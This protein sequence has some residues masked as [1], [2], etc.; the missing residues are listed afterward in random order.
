MD[1]PLKYTLHRSD[2]L[3]KTSKAVLW[4]EWNEDGTF[5]EK[6][7]EPA[8]G[9]SLLMSPF[10]MAFTWQTTPITELLE[11]TESVIKF[12]T[13]NSHYTLDIDESNDTQ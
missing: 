1:N 11:V 13:K 4:I 7:N 12:K 2:G 5:K 9:L 3:A 10:N 8:V 6:H